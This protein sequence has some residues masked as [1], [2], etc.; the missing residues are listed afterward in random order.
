ML[1]L[2]MRDAAGTDIGTLAIRNDKTGDITTGNYDCEWRGRK[3]RVERYPRVKGAWELAFRAL[4]A[5]RNDKAIVTCFDA[6]GKALQ[7]LEEAKS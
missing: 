1:Y 6:E 4:E 5:I 3:C 7:A 2:Y